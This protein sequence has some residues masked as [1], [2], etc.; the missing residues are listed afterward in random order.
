MQI[1]DMSKSNDLD[2]AKIPSP[3]TPTAIL[4]LGMGSTNCKL[5]K[6]DTVLS[7]KAEEF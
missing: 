7:S 3:T 1:T 4:V 2:N 6:M 5:Q